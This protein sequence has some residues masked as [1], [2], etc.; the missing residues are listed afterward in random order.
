[1]KELS[2]QSE[3]N[4]N[5]REDPEAKITHILL[6]RCFQTNAVLQ[7]SAASA[8]IAGKVKIVLLPELQNYDSSSVSLENPFRG[9]VD[10]T[11]HMNTNIIQGA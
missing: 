5:A 10:V 9:Q 1:M 8:R 4:P 2:F 11:T 3:F 6:T 7:E